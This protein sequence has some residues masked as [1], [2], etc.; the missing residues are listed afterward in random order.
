MYCSDV[1]SERE[2]TAVATIGPVIFSGEDGMAHGR[3][4]GTSSGPP[5]ANHQ[6]GGV[7]SRA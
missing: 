3:Q 5:K 1:S 4:G 2:P 7:V 6:D